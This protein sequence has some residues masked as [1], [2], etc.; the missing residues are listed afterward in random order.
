M[1]QENVEVVRRAYEAFQA[2]EFTEMLGLLDPNFEIM[3]AKEFPGGRR[4]YHGHEGFLEFLGEW[5]DPWDECSIEL[6]ELID[7]GDAVITVEHH[8]GRRMETGAEV[9]QQV[10]DIW[11]IKGEA[12]VAC[13]IFLD[14]REA[15]EAAGLSE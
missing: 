8:V 4:V 3:P 7:A 1:S 14:K 6:E 12:L 11:T 13:R 2:G 9:A 15:L 10:S 5:F